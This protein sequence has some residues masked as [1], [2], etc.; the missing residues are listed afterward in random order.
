M[1]G[2]RVFMKVSMIMMIFLKNFTKSINLKSKMAP[3]IRLLLTLGGSAFM[4]HLTNTMF[5]SS[6]PGMDDV[7]SQNPDLMKQFASAAANTVE[8]NNRQRAAETGSPSPF[9][10]LGNLN[11][12]FDGW[13]WRRRSR[14]GLGDM[15]G[16][17][18]GGGDSGEDMPSR[19]EMKGPD[20]GQLIKSII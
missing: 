8:N 5:K 11:G 15:M 6:L 7:M 3:E 12:W 13:R 1:V 20:Y 9:A 10:G 4:F 14:G 2:L 16:G 19:P 17:L 18:M